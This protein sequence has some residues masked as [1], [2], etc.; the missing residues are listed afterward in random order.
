MDAKIIS[1][2]FLR[3]LNTT[4]TRLLS[5]QLRSGAIHI[6]LEQLK[7]ESCRNKDEFIDA[8]PI[9]LLDIV[10]K[11]EINRPLL[12]LLD[13]NIA[14]AHKSNQDGLSI[15][16]SPLLR[17]HNKTNIPIEIHFQQPKNQGNDHAFVVLKGGDT[18][19]DS[20]ASFDAL[21]TSG[22]SKKTL[23]S[24]SVDPKSML[25]QWES[26]EFKCGKA[27]RLSG[28]SGLDDLNIKLFQKE[29]RTADAVFKAI[30]DMV[31]HNLMG[32][33]IRN[34]MEVVKAARIWNLPLKAIIK[35]GKRIVLNCVN[36][37]ANCF[38]DLRR[39]W[40][41][42]QHIPGIPKDKFPDLNLCLLYQQL[43]LEKFGI[44]KDLRDFVKK[45]VLATFQNFLF[46][47]LLVR[48]VGGFMRLD[49]QRALANSVYVTV[50]ASPHLPLHI[51]NHLDSAN[52]TVLPCRVGVHLRSP[53]WRKMLEL[54]NRQM[55]FQREL[56][57]AIVRKKDGKKP[58]SVDNL[59]G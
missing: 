55:N 22:G 26:D 57:L 44:T 27:A 56:E 28:L 20:T 43:Q 36:M 5:L 13:E 41:E 32:L 53:R 46:T 21:K 1:K 54:E 59:S 58:N 33:K 39:L 47:W 52:M 38:N 34:S 51:G 7:E 49:E 50:W 2:G 25:T 35:D 40:S 16:V 9:K 24:L 11:N 29:A 8:K 18:I 3:E 15:V 6:A 48:D 31:R 30:V 17:R 19:N 14:S 12:V 10:E 23:I 42:G 37:D 45:L 4:P